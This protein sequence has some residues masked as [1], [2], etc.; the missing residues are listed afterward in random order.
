M[1][2]KC[3]NCTLSEEELKLLNPLSREPED[4]C[5]QCLDE[6]TG[7]D[8][9]EADDDDELSRVMEKVS[10]EELEDELQGDDSDYF[11]EYQE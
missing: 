3:C 11:D 4:M 5:F 9:E 7:E 2:C 6:V 8:T 1:R 10:L